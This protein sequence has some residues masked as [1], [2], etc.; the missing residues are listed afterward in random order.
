MKQFFAFVIA[1]SPTLAVAQTADGGVR[2]IDDNIIR[3]EALQEVERPQTSKVEVEVSNYEINN[4][5]A[6]PTL[7]ERPVPVAPRQTQ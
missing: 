5:G 3:G 2:V 4:Q 6:I 7:V 1:F